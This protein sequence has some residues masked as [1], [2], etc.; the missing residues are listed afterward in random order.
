MSRKNKKTTT[1]TDSRTTKAATRLLET[2]TRAARRA[3]RST[4]FSE[5]EMPKV[6]DGPTT[7]AGQIRFIIE[8][9]LEDNEKVD[10]AIERLMGAVTREAIREEKARL[11]EDG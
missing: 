4:D 11:R 9:A 2:M 1:T 3:A 8:A 10:R 7:R 5:P 6:K